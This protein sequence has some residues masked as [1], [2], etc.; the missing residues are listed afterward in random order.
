MGP[1]RLFGRAQHG[2]SGDSG[3]RALSGFRG[4]RGGA[5]RDGDPAEGGEIAVTFV[6]ITTA[7]RAEE[8][9]ADDLRVA[10][11]GE[12]GIGGAQQGTGD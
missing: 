12:G 6:A 11:V 9:Q 5:T 4:E 1:Q 7:K 2:T 10:F 8:G 3:L